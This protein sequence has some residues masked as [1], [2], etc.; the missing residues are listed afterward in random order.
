MYALEGFSTRKNLKQTLSVELI[1][2]WNI[3]VIKIQL[4]RKSKINLY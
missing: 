4:G 1:K 2:F 3:Y